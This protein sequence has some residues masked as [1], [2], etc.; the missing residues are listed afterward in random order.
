MNIFIPQSIQTQIELEEIIKGFDPEDK[1][2]RLS[3]QDI[4]KL[5]EEKRLSLFFEIFLFT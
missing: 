1:G 5:G 3:V 4:Y 2:V